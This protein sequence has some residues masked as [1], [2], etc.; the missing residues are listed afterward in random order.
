MPSY[1]TGFCVAITRNGRSRTWVAPS[2]VTCVSCIASSSADCVF[3]DARLISST[4]TTFAKT[5]PG[6]KRNVPL[7]RSKTLTPV[8]SA[9][10]RSG[11][12]CTRWKSRSSER[13]SAFASTVLPDARHVLDEHVPLGEEAEKRQPE[14]LGRRVHRGAEV[15]DDALGEGRGCD[16]VRARQRLRS[17]PLG[18]EPRRA[19]ARP[20]RGS[21]RRSPASTPSRR[22]AR[23]SRVT[24]TTSLSG[25][26]KP[27]SSR[28]TS[29]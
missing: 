5:G 12:N 2:T 26:S 4:R 17:R 29:L 22:G 27:M 18:H 7:W 19:G 25:L 8:T 21:R 24:S 20:R 9:G 11:V 16:G 13:A 28:P 23:R 14:R 1:S 6:R 15:V 10:S 3:G